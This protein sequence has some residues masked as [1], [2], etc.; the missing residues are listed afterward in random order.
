[1]VR[2]VCIHIMSIYLYI[3]TYIQT[4]RHMHASLIE[5]GL[6]SLKIQALGL[7]VWCYAPK[8]MTPQPPQAVGSPVY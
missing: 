8:S 7:G 5:Q 2:F 6:G 4:D 1:M 3:H